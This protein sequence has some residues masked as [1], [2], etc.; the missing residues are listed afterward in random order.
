MSFYTPPRPPARTHAKQMKFGGGRSD[1][2]WLIGFRLTCF[3]VYN[4]MQWSW[5][6]WL[7][8][9]VDVPLL[10]YVPLCG[11]EYY[12]PTLATI[13]HSTNLQYSIDCPDST[14][15][16]ASGLQEEGNGFE[17]PSGQIYF[18]NPT[19]L[20]SRRAVVWLHSILVLFRESFILNKDC[21]RLSH[22]SKE[23]VACHQ[24][25]RFKTHIICH[26]YLTNSVDKGWWHSLTACFV[27]CIT[28]QKWCTS[29][30]NLPIFFVRNNVAVSEDLDI[31][32]L[33]SYKTICKFDIKSSE[34]FPTFY[35]SPHIFMIHSLNL[36]E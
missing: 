36:M 6:P 23:C 7:A 8:S 32:V 2:R 30:F 26:N 5:Y 16:R 21:T 11:F 17:P 1:E 10:H 25:R 24:G 22:F 34:E 35:R 13:W 9:N 27:Y 33:D 28:S 4:W 3:R 29:P 18:L 15:G 12:G 19:T 20:C 31:G 14:V